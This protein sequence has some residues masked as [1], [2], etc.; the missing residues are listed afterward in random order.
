MRRVWNL[1]CSRAWNLASLAVDEGD[2]AAPSKAYERKAAA[3]MA[4]FLEQL[5]E[6][7][8]QRA[9]INLFAIGSGTNTATVAAAENEEE[10]AKVSDDDLD[11]LDDASA[12]LVP[13]SELQ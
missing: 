1:C 11:D 6:E 2:G 8:E 3:D 10:E 9:Q 7:P 12:L 5:E 13:T 4:A